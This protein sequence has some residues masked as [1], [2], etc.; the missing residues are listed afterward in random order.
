MFDVFG[1][2]VVIDKLRLV[3]VDGLVIV[4][5]YDDGNVLGFGVWI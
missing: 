5:I 1:V 3:F 4:V 2:F